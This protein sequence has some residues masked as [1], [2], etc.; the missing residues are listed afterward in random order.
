MVE[1]IGRY[2]IIEPLGEGGFAIVHRGRD[3]VLDRPVALKELRPLL[4]NDAEWV[5]RFHREAKTIAR[6]DHARIVPIYDVYEADQRL[7]IVMRLVEG[8]SLEDVIHTQKQ[9]RWPDV[10]ELLSAVAEGLSYA[11]A[12][13]ILHRDLKP[14][15]ILIDP[16]QGA[17]LSDFG[18]AKLTGESSMSLSAS[19]SIVGTPHYIAPEIWEGKK[20]SPQSD[21][22]ALGCILFEALTGEKIFKG[23]TP[24]AVMMAHFTPLSLPQHWPSGVP[25]GIAKVLGRALARNPEERYAQAVEM[26]DAL[27]ALPVNGAGPLPQPGT[28][29]PP[30]EFQPVPEPAA[31]ETTART[32][33][34]ETEVE[35]ASPTQAAEP[36]SSP[37][38]QPPAKAATDSGSTHRSGA[39]G[40][41]CLLVGL[42][43][44]ALLFIGIIGLGGVCS[45]LSQL[46][47]P[48]GPPAELIA[49][50]DTAITVPFPGEAASADIEIDFGAGELILNPGAEGA[51]L[52]GMATYNVAQLKP[53]IVIN[54]EDITIKPEVEVDL[55]ALP[56]GEVKNNWDLNLADFPTELT[57]NA[58]AAKSVLELGGLSLEQVRVTGGAT[59]LML[60]FSEPNHIKME[61]LRFTGGASH[62]R[63]TGLT[64]AYTEDILFKGGAGDYVLDFS[65][66]M[67]ENID[68]EIDAALG[69]VT[70]LI[71]ENIRAAVTVRDIFAS[72]EPTGAW[73]QPDV[74]E[75]RYVLPGDDD[76]AFEIEITVRI[77]A[78]NL[79]LE[80]L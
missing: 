23:D 12:Q 45:G 57:V 40:R 56:D 69:K 24:P 15:N 35:A 44:A 29:Q 1:K 77:G 21:I 65:G 64:N 2:E 60:S 75:R 63:L 49:L 37:P 13:A 47:S 51:L 61:S 20:S 76:A 6:L 74:D 9:L 41:G 7:F 16:K 67:R 42:S 79:R 31:T 34:T 59:D 30:S 4:L 19:G 48:D 33:E 70:L 22:Y 53:S 43:A 73:Q 58:G 38:D 39:R 78:G 36:V 26:V 8:P 3:T 68:V 54:D 5:A 25:H 10:I 71:P 55:S 72:V 66:E 50:Q 80:T 52:T 32:P 46:N 62:A 27:R 28:E 18:L 11:H 14:A 17:M